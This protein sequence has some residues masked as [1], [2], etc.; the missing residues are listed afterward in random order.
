MLIHL[1][2]ASDEEIMAFKIWH[3]QS[4]RELKIGPPRA[5]SPCLVL[6]Y[7]YARLVSCRWLSLEECIVL[8]LLSKH[9]KITGIR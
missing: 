8:I 5:C 7:V 9:K 4:I 1:Q 2:R 6:G 3:C